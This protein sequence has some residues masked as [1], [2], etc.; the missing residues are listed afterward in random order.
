MISLIT[1]TTK[2]LHQNRRQ[3]TAQKL[4]SLFEEL[5][6][7]Y[8]VA[9]HRY[10]STGVWCIAHKIGGTLPQIRR[11]SEAVDW[12]ITALGMHQHENTHTEHGRLRARIHCTDHSLGGMD[13]QTH[14]RLAHHRYEHVLAHAREPTNK[15][16]LPWHPPIRHWSPTA[17]RLSI[18]WFV[19]GAQQYVL[20]FWIVARRDRANPPH[21]YDITLCLVHQKN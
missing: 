5:L 10:T 14:L 12:F 2:S 1:N 18:A 20:W 17:T 7:L 21:Y 16:D 13:L 3:P 6:R 15:R 9:V 11:H 4:C 19:R 8:N